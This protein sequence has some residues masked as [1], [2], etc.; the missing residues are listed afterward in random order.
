MKRVF[1][2]LLAAVMLF[3]LTAC[4][5]ASRQTVSFQ[6]I[7]ME[8]P[9]AWKAEKRNSEDYAIYEKKNAKG[10]DYKLQLTESFGL[11][12]TFD[13][14]LERAG[15]FFLEVTGD[16]ASYENPSAPVAGKLGGV[17]DMHTI[18]CVYKMI[19][20]MKGGEASYP[21]KLIRVYMGDHDVEIQFSSEK[22]DFEAFDAAI[23]SAVC[24]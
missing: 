16:N 13:N 18:E 23:A 11:L 21:C 8:I 15:A 19:N 12:E 14:D 6:G 24:R 10:H 20:P 17:Y 4:G 3:S 9:K 1:A 5:G 22:G 7:S 2:V